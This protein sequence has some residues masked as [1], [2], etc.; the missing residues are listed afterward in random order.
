M[1]QHN[2]MNS[3]DTVVDVRIL[4][5]PERHPRIF[6]TYQQ[7]SVGQRLVLLNDH[8]PI[9]LRTEFELNHPGTYSWKASQLPA[10]DWQVLITK[11]ASTPAPRVLANTTQ[12][13]SS[14]A[15]L[16]GA[17]WKLEPT[18][19]D[20]D[21]NI[22][23]LGAGEEIGE[24]TGADLDVLIH[25]FQGSGTLYAEASTVQLQLGD[26]TYLPARSRRRILAG[27]DGIKYFSVHQRKKTLGLM[28][29]L[30]PASTDTSN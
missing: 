28:P 14:A 24:H 9:N 8:E 29:T 5:K 11:L 26:V 27:P 4:A 10:G 20:L 12:L 1:E 13:A 23:G 15:E 16:N 30:R 2:T 3:N 7:L 25:V 6:R 17:L 22:I 18:E 21:A 19:R